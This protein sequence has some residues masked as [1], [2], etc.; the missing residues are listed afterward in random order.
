MSVMLDYFAFTYAKI[1]ANAVEVA[2]GQQPIIVHP[3]ASSLKIASDML[4]AMAA[5]GFFFWGA[6]S[7]TI[8][9]HASYNIVLGSD[10]YLYILSNFGCLPNASLDWPV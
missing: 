2:A 1:V 10:G 5:P 4:F 6:R 8:R 7:V 9:F 3:H